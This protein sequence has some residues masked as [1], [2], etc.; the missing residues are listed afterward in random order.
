MIHRRVPVFAGVAAL[1]VA[2]AGCTGLPDAVA[3]PSHQRPSH[4]ATPT[5]TPAPSVLPGCADLVDPT[6]LG[7][8]LGADVTTAPTV[9][10]DLEPAA[11]G[12]AGCEL[13]FG[14][15][16]AADS[17]ELHY[18]IVPVSIAT[19]TELRESRT[20]S[21]RCQ[22]DPDIM[23]SNSG[24]DAV[25][26]LDGWWIETHLFLH[27][28][29]AHQDAAV[30]PVTRL[31][32]D[33]VRGR[34][35]PAV[36]AVAAPAC[37]ALTPAIASDPA[38][39]GAHPSLTTVPGPDARSGWPLAAAARSAGRA[40]CETSSAAA[41]SGGGISLTVLPG[42]PIAPDVCA[43]S[44]GATTWPSSSGLRMVSLPDDEGGAMLC[45][46]DGAGSITTYGVSGAD[47]TGPRWDAAGVARIAPVLAAALSAARG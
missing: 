3:S 10:P 47:A 12:G 4:S 39:A 2:L 9:V 16:G 38:I 13:R 11:V 42:S 27:T 46:A 41:T 20:G 40:Q 28:D 44:A 15:Q 14:R 17:A 6:A 31:V 30:S 8:A 7:R 1:L 5:S 25:T 35:P 26:V 36:A 43:Q 37:A 29:V 21:P 24:C 45:A 34:T 22:S 18:E 33:A 23:R 32:E 19:A